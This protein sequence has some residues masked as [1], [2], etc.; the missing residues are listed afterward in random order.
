LIRGSS[1]GTAALADIRFAG[2]ITELL[3]TK[4]LRDAR[5]KI[6]FVPASGRAT[7]IIESGPTDEPTKR[8][9][10]SK[11]FSEVVRDGRTLLVLVK[12]LPAP[13]DRIVVTTSDPPKKK[14]DRLRAK[15]PLLDLEEELEFA[16]QFTD[17]AVGKAV[18]RLTNAQLNAADTR[19]R[20]AQL[21]RD[22]ERARTARKRRKIRKAL[23]RQT[24]K[25]E[26]LKEVQ[27]ASAANRD[28]VGRWLKTLEATLRG[29]ATRECNDGTDN[30][31]DSLTDFGFDKDPGCVMRLDDDEVDAPMPLTCPDPGES[32]SVSATI[33]VAQGK[34]L[35]RFVIS[36]PPKASDEPRLAI[37]DAPVSAGSGGPYP[38]ETGIT[39]LCNYEFDFVYSYAVLT[40]GT[41]AGT[42]GLRVTVSVEN[43]G[44][45]PGGGQL[46]MLL[47][48]GTTR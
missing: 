11:G 24:A 33:N 26:R 48:A 25:L 3:G 29:P 31:R 44:G 10:G 13:A 8:R 7:T 4:G 41:P 14:V 20:I 35:E 2:P 45:Y 36:L 23:A 27:R 6:R 40:S 5:V 1:T 46:P 47:A 22:L 17:R 38:L 12:D 9:K 19:A 21:K 39:Q 16:V 15:V 32:R 37:V 34:A 30:D 18:D 43:N 28:L 42:Y